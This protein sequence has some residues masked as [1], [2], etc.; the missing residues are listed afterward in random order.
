VPRVEVQDHDERHAGIRGKRAQEPLERFDAA[1]GGAHRDH[2]EV[3]RMVRRCR[4]RRPTPRSTPT[5]V[6][7]WARVFRLLGAFGLGA[8]DFF[9]LAGMR[10]K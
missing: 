3:E 1:G 2:G 8:A 5:K 9:G 4:V 7:R 6:A 10:F